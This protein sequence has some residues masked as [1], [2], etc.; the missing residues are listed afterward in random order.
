MNDKN[1]KP[2]LP[3]KRIRYENGNSYIEGPIEMIADK[4]P[5]L[6]VEVTN[7]SLPGA[8]LLLSNFYSHELEVVGD[9]DDE[10]VI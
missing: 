3:K 7:C 8:R 6:V 1:G 10:T 4:F 2:I 9:V 5:V